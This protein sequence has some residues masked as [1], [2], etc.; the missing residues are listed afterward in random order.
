[1]ISSRTPPPL[2]AIDTTVLPSSR[3]ALMVMAGLSVPLSR[4]MYVTDHFQGAI[5]GLIQVLVGQLSVPAAFRKAL[6]Q[7]SHHV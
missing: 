7:E 4:K 1:M 3:H 2:S 5:H 6:K